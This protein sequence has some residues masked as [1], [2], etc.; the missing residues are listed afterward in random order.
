M[1]QIARKSIIARIKAVVRLI[2]MMMSFCRIDSLGSALSNVRFG[3]GLVNI[4]TNLLAL[5]TFYTED[6]LITILVE[7]VFVEVLF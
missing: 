2:L 5:A 6:I 3:S 7:T 1:K 4:F